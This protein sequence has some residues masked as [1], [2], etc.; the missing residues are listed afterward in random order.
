MLVKKLFFFYFSVLRVSLRSEE[1]EGACRVRNCRVLIS[2]LNIS[3]L[4]RI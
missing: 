1:A 3:P 2:D 4:S